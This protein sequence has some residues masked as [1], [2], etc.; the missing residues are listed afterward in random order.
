MQNYRHNWMQWD[1]AG[2]F[3]IMTLLTRGRF[4]GQPQ[5]RRRSHLRGLEC[6]FSVG[7]TSP[8][9][10]R[11]LG[12]RK[13]HTALIIKHQDECHDILIQCLWLR[14]TNYY[15]YTDV[16]LLNL[17]NFI[18]CSSSFSEG[19]FWCMAGCQT[20]SGVQYNSDKPQVFRERGNASNES[21]N[22]GICTCC[23]T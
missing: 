5:R 6:S 20:Q 13:D 16:T 10:E 7:G 18:L 14:H 3:I 12:N 15:Y 11:N 19:L 4:H 17:E 21:L 22:E 1:S 23:T 9:L 2:R 8:S